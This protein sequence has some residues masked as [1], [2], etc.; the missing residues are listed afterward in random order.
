[1]AHPPM[2]E[3]DH[4]HADC[5]RKLRSVVITDQFRAVLG[6]LLGQHWSEPRVVELHITPDGHLL[7]RC[8]GDADVRVLLGTGDDLIRQLHVAARMARL[9]GDE[10]GYLMAK[11]AEIKGGS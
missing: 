8:D 6:G 3:P 4:I 11:V 1:M 9:D 10:I 5:V 2:R 7:G